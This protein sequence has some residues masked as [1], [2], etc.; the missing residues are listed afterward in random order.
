M[1][2]RP[3]PKKSLGQNFLNDGNARRRM[4]AACAFSPGDVVLEIGP[5]QG[6]LTPLIAEHVRKVYAVELDRQLAALLAVTFA[7][8]STVAV[9]P[10]D[11]LKFDISS[12]PETRSQKMKVFGNIPYYITSPIIERLVLSRGSIS[13]I[14]LTVQKEFARRIAAGPGGKEYGSFSCFVQYYF[15]PKV[16]FD[17]KKNSFYPVPKVDSSFIRLRVREQT[18]VTV[19]DE[20]RLFRVIRTAF[21]QRRKTIRNSLKDILAG[22]ELE[23]AC[24]RGKIDPGARPE[25]LSLRDFA[26]LA[27]F[28]E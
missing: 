23:E 24:S 16:L 8:S 1:Q 25:R 14:F 6:A 11:I 21:Q 12:L 20:E 13:E 28:R 27:G 9:I 7:H 4:I 26:C 15:E 2:M 10:G 19:P 22:T 17:I 5:G 3:A 18:A